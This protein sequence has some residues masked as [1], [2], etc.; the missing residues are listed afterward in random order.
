MMSLTFSSLSANSADDKLIVFL[1]FLLRQIDTLSGQATCENGFCLPSRKSSVK[2]K[3]L[4]PFV[5]RGGVGVGWREANK[6]YLH[7]K[8]SR[9]S[10][11][12]LNPL[13]QI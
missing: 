13:R 2:G 8:N 4:L 12:V 9:K 6:I 3:N 5:G 1:F 7:C 11:G 10:T